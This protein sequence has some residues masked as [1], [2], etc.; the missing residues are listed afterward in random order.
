MPEI[1]IRAH[2]SDTFTS[3]AKPKSYLVGGLLA[4]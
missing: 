3:L 2:G 1:H 4:L